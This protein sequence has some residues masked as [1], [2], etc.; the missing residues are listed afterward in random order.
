MQPSFVQLS[1]TIVNSYLFMKAMFIPKSFH[2]FDFMTCGYNVYLG[3]CLLVFTFD[4][5]FL[6]QYYKQYYNTGN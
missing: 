4:Y 3:C 6:K 5:E 2:G 1:L